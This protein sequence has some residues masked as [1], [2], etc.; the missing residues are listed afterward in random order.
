M[1]TWMEAPVEGTKSGPRIESGATVDGSPTELDPWIELDAGVW[2]SAGPSP[3]DAIPFV[4]PGPD[5]P[6]TGP[7]EPG[8]GTPRICDV[9]AA[10]RVAARQMA[11]MVQDDPDRDRVQADVIGLRALHHELFEARMHRWPREASARWTFAILAWGRAP[12]PAR[13][14][15]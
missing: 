11:E 4:S 14:L 7:L 15:A 12:V 10:W 5:E 8:H 2:P 1:A 13:V 3:R 9:I 6:S